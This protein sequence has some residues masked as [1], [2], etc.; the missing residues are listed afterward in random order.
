MSKYV[1]KRLVALVVILFFVS[2]GTFFLV[3][4]LP[5]NPAYTILG[6]NATPH[7]VALV[8]GQLGLNSPLYEQYFIWLGNVFQGNLGQSFVTHETVVTLIANALPIDVELI[9]ISQII[10]FCVAVPL[11]LVVARRPNKG[12][13]RFSTATT[14]ACSPCRPSSW[15]P[16]WS[17]SSRWT[18]TSSRGPPPTCR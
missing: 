2:L 16:S 13:D 4:L 14:F 1:A 18:S 11:A 5:G 9:I 17:C 10:A 12:L 6:P 8:D 7:N 3:H 15:P